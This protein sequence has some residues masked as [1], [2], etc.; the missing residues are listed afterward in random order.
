MF[1]QGCLH[2]QFQVAKLV[3]CIYSHLFPTAY[4]IHLRQTPCSDIHSQTLSTDPTHPLSSISQPISK[5]IQSKSSFNQNSIKP[6]LLSINPNSISSILSANCSL[7]PTHL[8][9]FNQFNSVPSPLNP[10][11]SNTIFIQ[12]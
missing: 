9:T 3:G 12:S 5:P 7:N 1:C 6:H 8:C 2:E 4:S 11:K 10:F